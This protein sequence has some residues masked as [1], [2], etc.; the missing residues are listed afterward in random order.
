MRGMPTFIPEAMNGVRNDETIET[1]RAVRRRERSA[2]GAA[3]GVMSPVLYRNR[4]GSNL[5]LF[6]FRPPPKKGIKN[7]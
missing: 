2:A 4:T 6:N 1:A 5:Y 3:G 7:V